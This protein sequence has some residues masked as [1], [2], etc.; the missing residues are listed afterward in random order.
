MT[1]VELAFFTLTQLM[2]SYTNGWLSTTR[3]LNP[4]FV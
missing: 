1:S 3:I 4:G 2:M